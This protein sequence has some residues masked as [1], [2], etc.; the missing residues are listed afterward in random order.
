MGSERKRASAIKQRE[1]IACVASA[2][3]SADD[4]DYITTDREAFGR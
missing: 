2:P 4:S 3:F 1:T